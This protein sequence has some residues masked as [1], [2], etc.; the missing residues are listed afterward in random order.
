L[1]NKKEAVMAELKWE[2][3]SGSVADTFGKK[4]KKEEEGGQSDAY[5]TPKTSMTK[6]KMAAKA[7]TNRG[8]TPTP[9][10]GTKVPATKPKGK[11]K[12]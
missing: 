5:T 12:P 6:S 9:V 3:E 1:V 2:R 11:G 10:T 8:A 7:D 4:E